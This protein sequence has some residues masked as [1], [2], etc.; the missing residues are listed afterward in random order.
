MENRYQKLTS[1]L[2]TKITQYN[3]QEIMGAFNDIQNL[4]N[5]YKLGIYYFLNENK[6]INLYSYRSEQII[7]K[8]LTNDQFN[9]FNRLRSIDQAFHKISKNQRLSY[10]VVKQN[11]KGGGRYNMVGG[12][13]QQTTSNVD[14]KKILK[15]IMQKSNK[16][17]LQLT[18]FYTYLQNTF[19]M[20]DKMQKLLSPENFV[21]YKDILFIKETLQR[22]KELLQLFSAILDL[23]SKDI[24]YR[25]LDEI[26]NYL[27]KQ[28]KIY[29]RIK[30]LEFQKNI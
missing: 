20:L 17:I 7:K 16:G 12:G 3:I 2:K 18:D 8:I 23:D 22:A 28:L 24:N 5:D 19:D 13:A 9:I 26:Q 21:K 4:I 6:Y 1:G 27:F 25:K 29:I 30:K 15:Q 10:R 11:N 14:N